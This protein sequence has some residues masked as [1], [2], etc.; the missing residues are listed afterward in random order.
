[1]QHIIK[2]N[3]FAIEVPIRAGEIG[4]AFAMNIVDSFVLCGQPRVFS[5]LVGS[6]DLERFPMREGVDV[7][8]AACRFSFRWGLIFFLMMALSTAPAQAKP[9]LLGHCDFGIEQVRR[10]AEDIQFYSDWPDPHSWITFQGEPIS[11]HAATRHFW[12]FLQM[13]AEELNGAWQQATDLR[14]D[15]ETIRL[16]TDHPEEGDRRLLLIQEALEQYGR[17]V[18]AKGAHLE[19]ILSYDP[20]APNPNPLAD[21]QQ[22]Y[23]SS[24]YFYV[25]VVYNLEMPEAIDIIWSDLAVASSL[26]RFAAR[27][28]VGQVNVEWTTESEH[29][30]LGFHI[31]RRDGFRGRFRPVTEELIL[32]V[33]GDRSPIEQ[34]YRWI[35]RQIDM[36]QD[37]QYQ[38]QEIGFDGQ[39]TVLG[40]VAVAPPSSGTQPR[41]YQLLQNYPNPFNAS[42]QICYLLSSASEVLIS[43]YDV[44]GRLVRTLVMGYREAGQH[45]IRWDGHTNTGQNAGSG[46]YF[47]SFEAH[48][49]F[50][51]LKMILLR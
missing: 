12:L 20:Q 11:S 36:G 22:A 7:M 26:L 49:H 34:S 48:D 14:W 37:Y 2:N 18:S 32:S 41:R 25:L 40:T 51:R 4:M 35:D 5:T 29:R 28:G 13:S 30:A 10:S 43:I 15:L 45:V 44:S 21:F 38:L 17:D 27:P 23:A 33:A 6:S 39:R 24:H 8:T 46:L 31:F 19:I 42:T 1:L 47:C 50:Q 9:G 3:E 16:R